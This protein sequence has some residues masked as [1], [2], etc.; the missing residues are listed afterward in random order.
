MEFVDKVW[1]GLVIR[2]LTS[3]VVKRKM[4][5]L[6]TDLK[7]WDVDDFGW[8]E[9]RVEEIVRQINVCDDKFVTIF[10]DERVLSLL[11]MDEMG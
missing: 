9:A 7:R 3:Y 10:G 6:K 4:K 5:L 8:L 1:K 11:N 2:E